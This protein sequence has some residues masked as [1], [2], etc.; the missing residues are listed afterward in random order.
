M[1]VRANH[2]SFAGVTRRGFLRSSVASCAAIGIRP[3]A[4]DGGETPSVPA[5]APQV[6]FGI[7]ADLHYADKD[8]VGTR[9]YRDS[10]VKLAAAK[11]E[12]ARPPVDFVAELGDLI[13][14]A[15]DVAVER[16]YLQRISAE[17]AALP[18]RRYYVLGNHCVDTLT[19]AEF[20]QITGQPAAHF[21]FACGGWHFIV[22]D[23]CYRSDGAPYGRKNSTWTDAN[24][25]AEELA[26]LRA[27]LQRAAG[28]C[29]VFVHQRLDGTGAYFIKNAA[30]VREALETSGRVRAV[31]QGHYHKNAYNSIRGIHYCTVAAMIEG[32][33]VKHN[34]FA[35]VSLFRDGHIRVTGFGKQ[36]SYRWV[37]GAAN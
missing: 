34:A 3:R 18:G 21:S 10:L 28:P 11:P 22:L 25:P 8:P 19:K 36:E 27:D 1:T 16:S 13:D 33:G 29:L 9:H 24:M 6:R 7:M 30:A 32:S 5:E 23:G 4:G 12:F 14:A 20:L 26:W 31:F 35:V 15:P 2:Q 37:P 17:L